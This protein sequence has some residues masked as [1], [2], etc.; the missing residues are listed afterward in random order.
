MADVTPESE[1]IAAA[2]A[3]RLGD[4]KPVSPSRLYALCRGDGALYNHA[5]REAG[6]IVEK[7]TGRPEDPC[8]TCGWSAS[9]ARG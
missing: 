1:A 4:Q 7:A 2:R 5:L 9:A 6:Y 8:S 3:T